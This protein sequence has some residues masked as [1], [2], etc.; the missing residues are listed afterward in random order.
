MHESCCELVLYMLIEKDRM[1][2]GE[3][4]AL[5]E[6]GVVP[7]GIC[8]EIKQLAM[9]TY[10]KLHEKEKEVARFG[11]CHSREENNVLTDDYCKWYTWWKTW[12]T[13]LPKEELL[14]ISSPQSG[15]SFY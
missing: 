1:Q 2:V 3:Y 7:C 6:S 4:V 13:A 8:P 5:L 15:I 12:F 10:D 14:N 11:I 9:A